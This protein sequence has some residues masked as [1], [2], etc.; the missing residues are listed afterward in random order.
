MGHAVCCD[1]CH[2]YALVGNGADIP[3]GDRWFQIADVDGTNTVFVCSPNCALQHT[4]TVLDTA[5]AAEEADET[6]RA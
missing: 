3:T 5:T 2:K 6:E 1:V 4:Q